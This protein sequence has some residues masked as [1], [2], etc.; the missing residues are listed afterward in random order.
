MEKSFKLFYYGCITYRY[1]IRISSH[2]ILSQSFC[3]FC[4]LD[5]S[6]LKYS[7][8]RII[9]S[10]NSSFGLSVSLIL[11]IFF[12]PLF[13]CRL[14]IYLISTFLLWFFSRKLVY[15][16]YTFL[17]FWLSSIL[18]VDFY[19]KKISFCGFLSQKNL[20]Q[21]KKLPLI[22]CFSVLFLSGKF[23]LS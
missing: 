7:R 4:W 13:Y 15:Y 9:V 1:M 11:L 14:L 21:P 23:S 2:M 19:H 18:S 17:P 12:P 10:A 5:F 16:I 6:R 20:L 3:L 8:I 22:F